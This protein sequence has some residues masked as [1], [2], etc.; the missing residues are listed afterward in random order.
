M[1][2]R[3]RRFRVHAGQ[4]LG[5]LSA[6]EGVTPSATQMKAATPDCI[7]VRRSPQMGDAA[8]PPITARNTAGVGWSSA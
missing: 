6:G 5:P 7:G 4:K 1:S 3:V 8:D 2:I